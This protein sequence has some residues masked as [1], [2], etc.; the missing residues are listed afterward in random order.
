MVPIKRHNR[1]WQFIFALIPLFI[2]IAFLPKQSVFLLILY[3]IS[4]FIIIGV[5]PIFK[6][7]EN[8]WMF[9][10]VAVTAIPINVNLIYS[11]VNMGYLKE[12][13]WFRIILWIFLIYCILFSIEEIVFGVI[14]RFIWRKQYKA[15][16]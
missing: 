14:T 7:R 11:F 4:L 9:L 10:L 2:S 8:L 12:L 13:N 3:V 16:I 1:Y 5:V 6:K 15:K